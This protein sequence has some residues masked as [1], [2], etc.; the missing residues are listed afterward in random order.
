M[1][2]INIIKFIAIVGIVGSVGLTSCNDPVTEFGYDGQLSG[3]IVDANGNKVPG[4]IKL[5]TFAVQAR[6]DLDEVDMILR[7]KPDGTYAN[8]R[9]YPQSYKV[10]LVGPFYESPTA[11][12]AVDLTGGK[13]VEKDFQVTPFYSIAA[14]SISGNP[15][16]TQVMVNY[17]ITQNGDRVPNLR[18]VYVSTVS[19][20]TST[21]GS[22]GTYQTVTTAVT[23]NQGTATVSGLKPNTRY[24]IRIG[25]RATGQNLFNLSEQISFTTPGS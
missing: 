1:K 18:Q 6:G 13:V 16:S 15:T 3:K 20:P 17:N 24:F 19:W 14:P 10:R 23:Q 5:A 9:L 25:A 7:I 4:D 12:V 22:G 2:N 8:T 11:Q 21:T